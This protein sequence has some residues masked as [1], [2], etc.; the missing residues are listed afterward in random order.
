VSPVFDV[1]QRLLLVDLDG[2]MES[3][4]REVLLEESEAGARSRR[5]AELGVDVL[6]AGAVSAPLEAMLLAVGIHVIARTCGPTE[7]VLR[8]FVS[9]RLPDDAYLMPGCCRRRLRGGRGAGRRGFMA[10][11]DRT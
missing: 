8:A 11:E 3:E 9:R 1:A 4:R 5:I 7:E 10:K 6:I 2:D